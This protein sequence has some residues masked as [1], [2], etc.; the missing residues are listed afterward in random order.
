[1]DFLTIISKIDGVFG[2]LIM[3]AEYI[4]IPGF[5][6]ILGYFAT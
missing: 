3:L 2:F 6:G 1:M 5:F 4:G